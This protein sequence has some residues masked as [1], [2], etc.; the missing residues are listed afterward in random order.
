M[1]RPFWGWVS[2]FVFLFVLDF[3]IPFKILKDIPTLI[4][5]VWSNIAGLRSV[6]WTD[7]LQAL[8]MLVTSIWV[9]YL[10]V[11]KGFGNFNA[12]FEQMEKQIPQLLAGAGL[13]KFNIFFGLALPW[14]FS[15]FPIPR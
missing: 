7:A 15:P 2:W 8:I 5:M 3:I 1:G 6:A 11:D 13:F 10:V 9:L 4:A 14:L 12:F